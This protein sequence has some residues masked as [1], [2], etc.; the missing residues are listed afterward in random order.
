MR[1]IS[2]RKQ[3]PVDQKIFNAIIIITIVILAVFIIIWVAGLIDKSVK[4]D[5]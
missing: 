4:K 5:R 1:Q 3:M 2:E